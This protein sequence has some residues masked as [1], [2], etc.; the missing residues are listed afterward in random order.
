VACATIAA[1]FAITGM[2][3]EIN[4]EKYWKATITL[5]ILSAAFSHCFLL[6]IPTLA[7]SYRWTQAILA[8]FVLIL[9]LQITLAV[10]GEIHDVG[11]YRIMG[12][13]AVIVVLLTLIVPICSRLAPA[14]KP[15]TVTLTL[16]LEEGDVYQDTTT[17]Q[18]FR[19]TKI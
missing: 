19:V 1:I 16:L 14:I 8:I 2:W 13:I 4:D 9:S 11:Y 5:I 15:E 18:R 7:A 12:V 17:G 6:F 3:R 10:W